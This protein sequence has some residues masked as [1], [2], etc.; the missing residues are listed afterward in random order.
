M[1]TNFLELVG[2]E[3]L[4]VVSMKMAVFWVVAPWCV[5]VVLQGLIVTLG[6]QQQ[7][8][9]SLVNYCQTTLRYNTEDS[10]LLS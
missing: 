7:V 3:V 2:F 4:T 10:H 6:R 5:A 9:S 8:E 1:F